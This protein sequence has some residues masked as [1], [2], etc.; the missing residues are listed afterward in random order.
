MPYDHALASR[1]HAIMEREF[2]AYV[3]K[4]MFGGIAWMVQGNLAVGTMRKDLIVRLG[5]E[6][7]DAALEEEAVRP[8]DFTGKS[9]RGW[10]VVDASV[11]G[12][13][14]ALRGWV[15][16]GLEYALTLPPK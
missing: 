13:E 1:I 14:A 11:L 8:F 16:R 15:L 10:V 5:K 7:G 3:D 4:Q 9:M 12:S 2:P 6:G